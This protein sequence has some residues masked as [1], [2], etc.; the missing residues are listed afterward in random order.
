MTKEESIFMSKLVESVRIKAKLLQ[1][2]KIK[3]NPEFK[4]KDCYHI[5]AKA[6]GF[7]SWAE[8]KEVL[9]DHSVFAPPGAAIWHVW[10]S[11]YGKALGHLSSKPNCYLIPFQKHFFVCDEHYIQQLGVDSSSDLD[12][13]GNNWAEPKDMLAWKRLV[14]RMKK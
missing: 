10:Y 11:D 8:W 2:A 13:V 9:E 6:A 7:A 5:L 4:L 12:L 3:T 1:K 14:S